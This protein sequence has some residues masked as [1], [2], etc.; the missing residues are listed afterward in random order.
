VHLKSGLIIEA[1]FVRWGS[2][3][4]E[5]YTGADPGFQV[6]GGGKLKKFV[7]VFRVKNHDFMPK[8]HI[9]SN[10]RVCPPLDP[11]L[12]YTSCSCY[13]NSTI[14]SVLMRSISPLAQ[15]Q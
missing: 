10:F 4:N 1:A 12:L 6:R 14:S 9:F 2:N 5:D 15:D 8:N 7:G 3:K 13:H 11:P